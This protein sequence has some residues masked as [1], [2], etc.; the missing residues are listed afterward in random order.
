M[1]CISCNHEHNEKFCPNCG[2][3][4]GTPTITF[5]STIETTFATITNMDK[6]FLYNLKNLTT[7]PKATIEEYLKGKRKG[8]FNPI[9]FLIISITV[10]L[11]VESLLKVNYIA[12]ENQVKVLK[13]HTS[14]KIGASGGSFIKDYLKFFWIFSVIPLSLLTKL[15]F[16]RFNFAEHITINSFVLG[17]VTLIIGLLSFFIFRYSILFNPF[18]YLGLLWYIHRVFYDPKNKW[19]SFLKAFTITF[20]FIFILLLIIILIG[21]IKVN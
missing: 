9:S 20:L 12:T 4:T 6:G 16:K 13:D 18:I 10:Y 15:F 5:A 19:D 17:Q 3:K 2:E 21:L 14:Y 1:I 11:V 8:I 7:R